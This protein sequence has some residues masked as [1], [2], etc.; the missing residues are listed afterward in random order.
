ISAGAAEGPV[1]RALVHADADRDGRVTLEELRMVRPNAR[2]EEFRRYDTNNDSVWSVEDLTRAERRAF[3]RD[4][5][6]SKAQVKALAPNLADLWFDVFDR[7]GDGLLSESDHS[8]AQHDAHMRHQLHQ[9]DIN[10]DGKV[11]W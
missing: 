6:I 2:P 11:S 9:A 4:S 8:G 7:D 5:A 3:E 10:R 1:A